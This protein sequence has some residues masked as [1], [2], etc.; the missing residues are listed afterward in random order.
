MSLEQFKT[1]YWPFLRREMMGQIEAGVVP[2]VF[3]E[4][5]CTSWLETIADI[6]KGK[7]I[8]WF[9]QTDLFRA[10]EVL[11]D[12]VCLMGGVTPSLLNLGTPKD[13]AEHCKRLIHELGKGGGYILAGG[14]GGGIPDEARPENVKAMFRAA[15][16][17]GK[18]P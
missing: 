18:C 11:G 15:R 7:A 17:Y 10:K 1:F 14:G 16:D 13:V 3:W 9:E 4:G 12:V 6:P 2:C 5:D 8:Y